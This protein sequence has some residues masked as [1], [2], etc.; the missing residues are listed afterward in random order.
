MIVCPGGGFR[1]LAD[2]EAEPIALAY[3]NAG[4]CVFVLNY[5]LGMENPFP[6][7]LREAAAS[8]K[9]IK[10][11]TDEFGIDPNDVSITGFSAGGRN[12]FV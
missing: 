1:V 3:L 11:K 8:V 5:S 4:Y 12:N 10:E 7:A 6:A 2:S 9:L